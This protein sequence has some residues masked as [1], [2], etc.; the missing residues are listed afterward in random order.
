MKLSAAAQ[1][2]ITSSPLRFVATIAPGGR[3]SVSPKGAFLVLDE[4]TISFGEILSPQTVANLTVNPEL[5]VNFV[6]P[7]PRKGIRIR[8]EAEFIRRGSE[9]FDALIVRLKSVWD[10]LAERMNIIVRI[11]VLAAKPLSTPPYDTRATE[12]DMIALYKAKYAEIYP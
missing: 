2:C 4:E 9:T 11:P 1:T 10:S 6:D 8:G 7:F 5:E 12:D 3:P